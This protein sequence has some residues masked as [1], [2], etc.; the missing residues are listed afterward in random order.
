MLLYAASLAAIVA[1]TTRLRE[2]RLRREKAVLEATVAERTKA[3]REEIDSKNSFFSIVSHDLKNPVIG[4]KDL[5]GAVY[6]RFDSL[7]PSSA[8]EVLGKIKSASKHTADML[9]GILL[10]AMG[11]KGIIST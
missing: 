4:M 6:S 10:W 8:K 2:H 5:S 1:V 9:E 7:D 3:L 11:E